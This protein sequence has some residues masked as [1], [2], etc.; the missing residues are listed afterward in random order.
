MTILFGLTGSIACGKSTVSRF[1]AEE[2]VAVVDAD[3]I[4]RDVVVPG[5]PGLQALVDAFGPQYLTE[6]GC[7]DRPK[8]AD[9][10]F[11]DRAQLAICDGIMSEL[12]EEE[13][14]RKIQFFRDQG[15]EMIV[16]DAALLIERGHADDFRP[17]VVVMTTPE[18]QLQRLMLRNTLTE[19][20]AQA[21]IDKQ[22][23]SAEKALH[24][25]YV[26]ESIGSL[27]ELRLKT[28]SVL[29]SIA[30]LASRKDQVDQRDIGA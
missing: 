16:Y 22:L 25:D 8:L 4:A 23:T 21:R 2:G 7:L 20:Q 5:S 6:G 24:A 17:L 1:M 29:S 27:D 10:V 30:Q 28:L 14:N 19:D 13:S 18:I 15:R 12:I 26:I 11:N 3:L 9:L